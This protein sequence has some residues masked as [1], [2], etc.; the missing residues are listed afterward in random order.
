LHKA[1]KKHGV[2]AFVFTHIADAFDE[3]SA[4]VIE[5]LLI[6]EHNTQAPHG[7]NLTGGGDG[8]FNPSEDVRKKI[9]E[10]NK[11]RSAELRASMSKK[12]TGLKASDETK[13]KQNLKKI[14]SKRTEETKKKMSQSLI[15]N[16]R[17]VVKKN[18][19]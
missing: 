12:L 18:S 11:N 14:G 1:I 5:R 19:P 2:D 9:A 7:Y 13:L 15:G 4:F 16:T 3:E 10:A 6:A 8:L 17:M